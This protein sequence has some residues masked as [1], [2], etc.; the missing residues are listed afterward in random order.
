MD[1][2]EY[3]AQS[4]ER[5]G[6]AAVG[7]ERR[8]EDL[9]RGAAPVSHWMLDQLRLQP[10]HRVLELAAG[11]A[12]T[13]LLAAEL[14]RPAGGVII[15]D[16]AEEMVDVAR[17]RAQELGIDNAEVK[18]MEAEWIDLPAGCVAGVLCRWGFMLL[19]DPEAA[20]RETR[21]VLR[22][23]G[24]LALAAWDEPDRN[25][26]MSV[27][28]RVMVEQGLAERPQPGDPGPFAFAAPGRLE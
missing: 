23:G 14:V 27:L 3:R 28:G 17:R 5:W 8:R 10:G 13:G 21:R 16:Q 1:P 22:P 20:L 2:E 12:D 7:W 15:T 6:R 24:R 9:Q 26:A 18:V 11:P 4:R 19:A 25:P